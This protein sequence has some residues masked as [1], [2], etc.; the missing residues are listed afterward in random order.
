METAGRI[1]TEFEDTRWDA[2][3]V[4]ICVDSIGIGAGL[5][6][7]L[8]ELG[9][10]ARGVNVAE[11]SAMGDRFMRLRDELW[12]AAREW[13]EARD[14]VI[15]DDET[16]INELCLP[17]YA[18]PETTFSAPFCSPPPYVINPKKGIPNLS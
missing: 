5:V 3:P 1:K 13:L 16:L 18:D 2:K 6:D 11:S 14:C 7:R 9:L 4:E 15:P 12:W 10:P 8:A 17:R